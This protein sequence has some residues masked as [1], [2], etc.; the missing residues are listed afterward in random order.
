MDANELK[1]QVRETGAAIVG[2][3]ESFSE[4]KLNRVPFEGSWT[5]GQV[6]E[7]LLKSGGITEILWG[8]TEPAL[9]APDEKLGPLSIFLDFTVKFKSPD[10]IVPSDGF[11]AK[12][13]L[14][15]G[16]RERW[17]KIGVAVDTLDLSEVC[18]DFEMPQMGTLTRLELIGFQVF[19]T[20]RHLHQL[21]N[22]AARLE[23]A[24]A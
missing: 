18:K 16:L 19:H 7:H 24:G 6:G 3:M 1:K 13:P 10:F 22:I 4:D 11:H 23:G 2:M 9:R 12:E 17:S 14:V 8:R 21:N 15:E 20:K 5:A